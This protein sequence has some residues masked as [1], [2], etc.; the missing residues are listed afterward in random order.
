MIVI[1]ICLFWLSLCC[2]YV[3]LVVI[4]VLCCVLLLFIIFR[5]FFLHFVVFF[6]FIDAVC[7]C[8][9][10]LDVFS[11]LAIDFCCFISFL[12]CFL[13][14]SLPACLPPSLVVSFTQE[15]VFQISMA[16]NVKVNANRAHHTST[17]SLALLSLANIAAVKT[18]CSLLQLKLPCGQVQNRL[19]FW[20]Q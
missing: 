7:C 19:L 2:G 3:F 8:L 17:V 6:V 10:L 12:T 16:I 1:N 18:P 13:P 11:L 5:C 9:L 15:N 14:A 4:V 20:Y